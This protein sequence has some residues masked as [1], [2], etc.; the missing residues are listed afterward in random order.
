LNSCVYLA[1]LALF[2]ISALLCLRLNH[3]ARD[4]VFGGKVNP[5]FVANTVTPHD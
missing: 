2:V 5:S 4:T 3:S 1:L